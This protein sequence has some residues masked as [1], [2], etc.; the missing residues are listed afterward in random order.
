M[1]HLCAAKWPENSYKLRNDVASAM[2]DCYIELKTQKDLIRYS[3]FAK[4]TDSIKTADI[5]VREGKYFRD[6]P[7]GGNDGMTKSLT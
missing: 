4:K 6:H 3:I 2:T 7:L 1:E 5:H